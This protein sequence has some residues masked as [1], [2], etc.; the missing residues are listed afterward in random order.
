MDTIHNTLEE[1]H[2]V[3][4]ISQ[5]SADDMLPLVIHLLL[6]TRIESFEVD[7]SLMWALLEP[8]LMN[9]EAGYYCT[10]FTVAVD[11][12]R[13]FDPQTIPRLRLP[14]VADMKG[15]SFHSVC[16]CMRILKKTI[17]VCGCCFQASFVLA[18]GRPLS[19][20]FSKQFQSQTIPLLQMFVRKYAINSM[21]PLHPTSVFMR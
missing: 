6:K 19:T 13:T 16:S 5:F 4:G 3:H 12:I 1:D 20:L 15:L 7:A 18:L 8:Q 10:T 9:G 2:S 21:Y 14:T 17:L 11:A